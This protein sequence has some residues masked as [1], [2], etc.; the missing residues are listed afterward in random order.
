M[1]LVLRTNK[2]K[3]ANLGPNFPAKKYLYKATDGSTKSICE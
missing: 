1:D 3:V 2:S